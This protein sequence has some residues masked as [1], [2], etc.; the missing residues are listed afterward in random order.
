MIYC[1]NTVPNFHHFTIHPDVTKF[2]NITNEIEKYLSFENMDTRK[3]AFQKPEEMI[4]IFN[5]FPKA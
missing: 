3:K 2:E 5:K 4:E 1:I